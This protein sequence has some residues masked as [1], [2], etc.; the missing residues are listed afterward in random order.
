MRV[1]VLPG[2]V[3]RTQRDPNLVDGTRVPPPG[4]DD[5]EVPLRE[6]MTLKKSFAKLFGR[7]YHFLEHFSS[8]KFGG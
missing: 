8:K 5:P 3:I 6:V 7:L 1:K 2:M 4:E